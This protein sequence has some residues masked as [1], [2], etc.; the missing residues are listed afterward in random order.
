[1]PAVF[2]NKYFALGIGVGVIQFDNEGT[3]AFPH[4]DFLSLKVH[5]QLLPHLLGLILLHDLFNINNFDGNWPANAEV[6]CLVDFAERS[7][8]DVCEHPVIIDSQLVF[9]LLEFL[10]E[11]PDDVVISLQL[12]QQLN[13]DH[14]PNIINIVLFSI[15]SPLPLPPLLPQPPHPRK[16]SLFY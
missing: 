2:H 10:V 14:L 9:L 8:A 3:V 16:T 7:L 12:L 1:M 13:Y 4:D 15:T 11:L 5:P 6:Y